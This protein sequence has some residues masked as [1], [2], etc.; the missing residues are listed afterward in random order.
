MSKVPNPMQVTESVARGF[1][2][3]PAAKKAISAAIRAHPSNTN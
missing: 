3:V 2:S 1:E